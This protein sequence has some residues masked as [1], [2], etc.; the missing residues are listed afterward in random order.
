MGWTDDPFAALVH[1][2]PFQQRYTGGTVFHLHLG[3]RVTD[4]RTCKEL[5]RRTLMR[6]RIP[7]LTVTPTFSVCPRHGYLDGEHAF[8]PRCETESG[9]ADGPARQPCEVW[10]RVMGYYRP[11]SQFNRGKQSEYRERLFYALPAG[12][13]AP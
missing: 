4:A 13:A 10:T 9:S 1:Q 2:E 11:V 8:C 7:Y 12:A 6:F 5:V 3:E